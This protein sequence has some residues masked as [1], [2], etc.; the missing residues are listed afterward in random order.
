MATSM[1]LIL[2]LG[3]IVNGIFNKIKLPG[4]LGMLILGVIIGPYGLNLLS[5]SILTISPDIRKIA[6]IIILLRAGLGI[7]KRELKEVGITAIKFSCI[8]ALLL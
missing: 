2:L 6:L 3:F 7:N 4:L 1:A 8:P 5:N